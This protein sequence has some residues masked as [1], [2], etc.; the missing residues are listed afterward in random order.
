MTTGKQGR[1][2]TFSEMIHKAVKLVQPNGDHSEAIAYLAARQAKR[3][4][5]PRAITS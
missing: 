1:R 5:R 2:E 3:S 4:R